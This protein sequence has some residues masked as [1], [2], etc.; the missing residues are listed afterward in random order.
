VRRIFKVDFSLRLVVLLA[1]RSDLKLKRSEE[2]SKRRDSR[3]IRER[4]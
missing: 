2:E 1:L 4:K 3:A